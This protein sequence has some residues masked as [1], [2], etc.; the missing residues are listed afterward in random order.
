[1]KDYTL[2]IIEITISPKLKVYLIFF[3][4]YK[5]CI[6][7]KQFNIKKYEDTH[8]ASFHI[9]LASRQARS[10]LLSS[11]IDGDTV[12]EIFQSLSLNTVFPGHV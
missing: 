9:T 1:M 12:K 5:M 10:S 4:L 3:L 2:D 11:R 6:T 8:P 7:V